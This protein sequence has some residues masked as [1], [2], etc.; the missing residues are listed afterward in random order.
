MAMITQMAFE[1][2]MGMNIMQSLTRA[3]ADPTLPDSSGHTVTELAE[4]IS[5]ATSQL[6]VNGRNPT[7]AERVAIGL[8][9]TVDVQ[10]QEQEPATTTPKKTKRTKSKKAKKNKRRYADDFDL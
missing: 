3:G 7:S 1:A 10:E 8:D 5:T 6:P 4:G 2:N 9:P